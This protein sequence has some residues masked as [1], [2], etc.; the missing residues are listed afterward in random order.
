MDEDRPGKWV[1]IPAVQCMELRPIGH[2]TQLRCQRWEG[3]S[4]RHRW[5]TKERT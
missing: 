1:W 3:H 5:P 2:E 4:G